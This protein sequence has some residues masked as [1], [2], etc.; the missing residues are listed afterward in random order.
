MNDAACGRLSLRHKCQLSRC[1]SVQMS[2][3]WFRRCSFSPDRPT[4]QTYAMGRCIHPP[5]CARQGAPLRS[6]TLGR[7]GIWVGRYTKNNVQPGVGIGCFCCTVQSVFYNLLVH[8]VENHFCYVRD[9]ENEILCLSWKSQR[10]TKKIAL[11]AKNQ[12]ITS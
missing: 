6:T 2:W 8:F 9:G 12:K 5:G 3:T 4:Q 7:L 10:N 11:S 1:R